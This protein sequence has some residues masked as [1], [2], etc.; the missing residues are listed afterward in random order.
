MKT[1]VDWAV[2]QGFAVIDVNLPK[3]V[4]AYE[5]SEEHEETN[6]VDNRMREATTL[7]T[8][9]WENYIEL[10]DSSH[11]FMMGT[12]IGHMAIINFIK[13]HDGQAQR[14]ITEAISFVEDVSF[15]SCKSPT[16][17]ALPTWYYNHS[18]AFVSD[19]H[20]F[21]AS[22]VARK[23]KR[24][25][26]RV[27]KSSQTTISDMLAEHQNQVFELLLEDTEEWRA[28]RPLDDEIKTNHSSP[29]KMPPVSNF[30][31]SPVPRVSTTINPA[32]IAAFADATSSGNRSPT[33]LPP[34]SNFASSPR[35]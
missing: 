8:Y 34:I 16:N 32:G 20:H 28:Q 22:D 25:F 19:E 7:L 1:Y 24:R 10:N 11:I 33:K 6:S 21:W 12:N 9:L 2:K 23:P 35:R 29:S 30:A 31:L 26:G 13:A 14:L 17:D 5:D 18:L 15:V 27:Q 3:H 4:S